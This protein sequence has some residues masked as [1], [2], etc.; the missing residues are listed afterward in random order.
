[1]IVRSYVFTCMATYLYIISFVGIQV[2]YAV[3][4]GNF[5]NGPAIIRCLILCWTGDHPAQCE[6]GKFLGAGGLHACRRDK[7]T[8]NDISEKVLHNITFI[9]FR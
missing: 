7:V 5:E 1:M 2:D 4:V 3:K 8:G 6:V 9:R